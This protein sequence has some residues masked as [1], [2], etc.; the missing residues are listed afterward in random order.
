MNEGIDITLVRRVASRLRRCKNASLQ[1]SKILNISVDAARW[2]AIEIASLSSQ[3]KDS[4][5]AEAEK[6]LSHLNDSIDREHM[7]LLAKRL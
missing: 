2:L 4:N 3:L 7:E 5:R 1:V 6:L